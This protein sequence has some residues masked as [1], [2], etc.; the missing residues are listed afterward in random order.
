MRDLHHWEL[1]CDGFFC[2]Y[3]K[4]VFG[5]TFDFGFCPLKA[6]SQTKVLNQGISFF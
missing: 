6:K 1:G 2:R 5:L 4:G 3:T